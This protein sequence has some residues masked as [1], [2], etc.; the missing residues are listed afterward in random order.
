MSDK[1]TKPKSR[2]G[3]GLSSLISLSTPD[4]PPPQH[5]AIPA[6]DTP[7]ATPSDTSATAPVPAGVRVAE[8]PLS[9][10]V[11]NP[12]QP[13]RHFDETSLHELSASLK[14]TGMIQPIIVRPAGDATGTW[15][16]I[17][18]E[19]RWRAARLAD[20]P[21]VPAIIRDVDTVT[22]A[23]MAL[24]ENIQREDLNPLD[25]ALAYQA[26]IKQLGLTQAELGGRLGEDKGSVNHFLRLLE[27]PEPVQ[28]LVRDGRLSMGHAKL[29]N[30]LNSPG[31]QQR[32]A[33]LVVEQSLSVR[34]LERLIQNGQVQDPPPP[35]AAPTAAKPSA[36]LQ[37]LERTLSRELNL[38]AQ[39]RP[40][41]RKGHGRVVL[42]YSSLDQF[43]ELLSRLGVRLED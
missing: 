30:G 32:L 26:L 19:R 36:H 38:R 12:H 39:I 4:D 17:A 1:A 15:Q 22:Q 5:P 43:D 41:N 20:L 24:I 21:T 28:A 8:I 25:R 40:S 33:T 35:V 9:A 11:P 13:R 18:G 29:L 31:E 27:L 34:N 16:L 42:H 3:R 7:S 23:Q 37:E 14:S 2:L 10:I 6:T